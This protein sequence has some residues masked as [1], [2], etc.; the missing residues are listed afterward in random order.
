[1]TTEQE[2]ARLAEELIERIGAVEAVDREHVRI[3]AVRTE[4]ARKFT[5]PA[6]NQSEDQLFAS[7]LGKQSPTQVH[8]DKILYRYN[9]RRAKPEFG[10]R[11]YRGRG[12]INA[13][14]LQ[15]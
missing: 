11:M 8:I 4:I 12:P 10:G 6:Q 2:Y 15:A 14:R 5:F 13:R 7:W 1:M 3:A 9:W